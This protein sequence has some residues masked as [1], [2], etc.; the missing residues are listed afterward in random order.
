M[1]SKVT[2]QLLLYKFIIIIIIIIIITQVLHL[3]CILTLSNIHLLIDIIMC[4][5]VIIEVPISDNVFI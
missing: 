2:D 1:V 3:Q 4:I 5:Y